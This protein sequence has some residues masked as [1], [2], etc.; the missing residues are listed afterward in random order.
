MNQNSIEKQKKK[1]KN[2][3]LDASMNSKHNISINEKS[4]SV[5]K[6]SYLSLNY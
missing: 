5:S 3:D 2:D 1:K 6:L 4:K